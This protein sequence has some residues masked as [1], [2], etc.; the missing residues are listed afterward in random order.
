MSWVLK[1]FIDN[2]V[3]APPSEPA[4]HNDSRVVVIAGSD[5]TASALSNIIYFLAKHPQVL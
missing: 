1:A 5:T 2:D 4:L 3:S